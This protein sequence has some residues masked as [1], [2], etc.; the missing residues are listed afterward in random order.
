MDKNIPFIQRPAP[1]TPPQ[2]IVQQRYNG[3]PAFS[4]INIIYV[5]IRMFL[6]NQCYRSNKNH[7]L[8]SLLQMLLTSV[9]D[10][11]MRIAKV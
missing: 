6:S 9:L 3:P 5:D 8:S 4:C 2:D 11:A 10:V 7:T 1:G